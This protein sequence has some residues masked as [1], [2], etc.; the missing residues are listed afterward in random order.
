MERIA[1]I[2]PKDITATQS[3]VHANRA[4]ALIPIVILL[5]AVKFFLVKKPFAHANLATPAKCVIG[6]YLLSHLR[7]KLH[8]FKVA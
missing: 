3:W 7:Q 8:E 6:K 4:L 5:R 1:S 2:V